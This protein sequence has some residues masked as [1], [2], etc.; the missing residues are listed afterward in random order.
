MNVI[1][2]VHA[3]DLGRDARAALVRLPNR[4]RQIVRAPL[5]AD[6]GTRPRAKRLDRTVLAEVDRHED[7]LRRGARLANLA[8][9]VGAVE[10]RHLHIHDDHVGLQPHAL[11]DGRF[12]C[13]C[14]ADDNDVPVGTKHLT[15]PGAE[16]FALVEDEHA[17][18]RGQSAF[19]GS[20]R[21]L[22]S[23]GR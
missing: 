16:T 12:R 9:A 20:Q 21:T 1:P 8:H 23:A 4:I 13:I 22:P 19:A 7:D 15:K 17:D 11:I 10:Q 5:A 18:D 6:V 2:F 14:L 3:R